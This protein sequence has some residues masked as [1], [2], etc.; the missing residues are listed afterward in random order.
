MIWKN[1]KYNWFDMSDRVAIW[2]GFQ[3][4]NCENDTVQRQR[5]TDNA[6]DHW[7][8]STRTLESWRLF[9]FTGKCI[10]LTKK[11]RWTAREL[12]TNAINIESYMDTEYLHDLYFQ[13]DRWEDRR[14]KALVKTKPNWT[15]NILNPRI[16]FTFELYSPDNAVYW[17]IQKIA[18]WQSSLFWWTSF[19]N[20]FW[21][22]WGAFSWGAICVNAW[23]YKAGCEITI[24]WNLVN[25]L[26]KN[27]TNW[28]QYK[29]NWTTSNL[30][31]NSK[32]WRSV[33][34]W[35]ID[36]SSKREYWTAIMLDSWTNEIWVFADSWTATF[37][38]KRYDAWNTI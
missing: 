5:I 3:L 32:D 6:N 7:S 17:I 10:W 37:T 30:V 25:P 20:S 8:K 34:D 24:T 2:K 4:T 16:P 19:A 14:V 1:Y 31:L 35:W 29:I 22:S 12:I 11:E 33:T 27:L 28:Q 15:N 26:I 38:V 13:T 9:T 21:D 23:N 36:I 18:S